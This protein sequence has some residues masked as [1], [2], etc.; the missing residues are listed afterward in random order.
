MSVSNTKD[1]QTVVYTYNGISHTTA[2][3]KNLQLHKTTWMNLKNII[4]NKKARYT[5]YIYGI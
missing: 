3:I 5:K 2:K 1:K 4:L